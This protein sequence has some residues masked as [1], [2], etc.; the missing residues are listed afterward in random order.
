MQPLR[1]TVGARSEQQRSACGDIQGAPKYVCEPFVE[2][3]SFLR[4][5]ELALS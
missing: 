4:R 5:Q 3:R 1:R 2:W